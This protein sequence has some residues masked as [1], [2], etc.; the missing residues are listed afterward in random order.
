MFSLYLWAKMTHRKPKRK[1][2]TFLVVSKLWPHADQWGK[3]EWVHQGET[4]EMETLN[5]VNLRSKKGTNG[6]H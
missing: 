4:F 6:P 3:E 2:M 5:I 1:K